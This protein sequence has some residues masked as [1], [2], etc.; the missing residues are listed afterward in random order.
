MNNNNLPMIKKEG[1]FYKIKEWF[2]KTFKKEEVIEDIIIETEKNVKVTEK[3]SFRDSIKFESNNVILALQKKLE[4]KEI[5]I[6][7]LTDKELDE[8]IELYEKQIEEK[9]N[10]LKQYK[11]KF[12]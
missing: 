12:V 4:N 7:S 1:I 5:E 8:M 6:S 11:L 2:K 10:I 9:N 3:T